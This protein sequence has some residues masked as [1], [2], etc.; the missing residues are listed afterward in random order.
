[1][2][3]GSPKQGHDAIAE[4]L[5]HRALVAMH[6]VHHTVQGR[7]QELLSGLRV[8]VP[9][10][11][12]GVLDVGKQ[13]GDLLA[14]TF[15]VRAG[16]EDFFGEIGWGIRPGGPLRRW[17][18]REYDGWHWSGYPASSTAPD[19]DFAIFIHGQQLAV[20]EFFFE[21]SEIRV[22]QIELPFEG[23]IGQAPATL[24]HGNRLIQNLLEGHDR[25]SI[26]LV[27]APFDGLA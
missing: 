22:I 17:G 9:D 24:E 20:D 23:T 14:F 8:E 7:V 25:P 6:G 19:Q 16:V 13:H 5:V 2:G 1:M 11:F 27:L 21:I 18:R 3:N 15:Q 12:G 26:A 4:H 10:Q